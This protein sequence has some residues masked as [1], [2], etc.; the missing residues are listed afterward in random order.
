MAPWILLVHVLLYSWKVLP[1]LKVCPRDGG[2]FSTQWLPVQIFPATICV[3]ILTCWLCPGRTE[4]CPPKGANGSLCWWVQRKDLG[5]GGLVS[6][7]SAACKSL[8][9]SDSSLN[10][11]TSSLHSYTVSWPQ[12]LFSACIHVCS[13]V[14]NSLQPHG[15]SPARLLCPWDSPGKNTAVGN[16]VL[17]PG[18]SRPRDR[19]HISCIGRQIL[20]RDTWEVP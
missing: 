17:L 7:G 19:T 6:I 14:S 18:Y 13:V 8:A 16:H 15:L 12:G 1:G 10:P 3:L 9:A 2:I 20:Y 4:P 11:S 5:S